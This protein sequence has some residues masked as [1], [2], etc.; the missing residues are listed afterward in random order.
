MAR[1]GI[2]ALL[3]TALAGICLFVLISILVG[4]RLVAPA[5]STLQAPRDL[6][7]EEVTLKS[8]SGSQIAGW[9]LPAP[10]STATLI[11]LHSVRSNRK[12]MMKRA[13]L[14]HA[15]GYGILAFDFQAHG[16]SPGD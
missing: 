7:C 11:L 10:H 8:H 1:P 6:H 14:F 3:G 9:F 13:R 15:A 2:K 4:N 16:E 12:T 5:R